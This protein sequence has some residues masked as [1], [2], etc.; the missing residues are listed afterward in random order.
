MLE[1]MTL[2]E[3]KEKIINDDLDW[4]KIS[5]DEIAKM[6]DMMQDTIQDATYIQNNLEKHRKQMEFENKITDVLKFEKMENIT[7]VN[8]M[9]NR[10]SALNAIKKDA[11]TKI[12]QNMAD[13][14]RSVFLHEGKNHNKAKQYVDKIKTYNNIIDFIDE[15]IAEIELIAEHIAGIEFF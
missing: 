12:N 1:N 9:Q 11:Q 4:N 13:F 10:I 8:R 3:L 5:K 14:A 7:D 6:T 2:K 15:Y